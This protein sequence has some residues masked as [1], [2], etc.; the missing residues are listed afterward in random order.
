MLTSTPA[1]ATSFAALIMK[2][3]VNGEIYKAAW[4]GNG[5]SDA[6]L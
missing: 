6:R 2:I 4:R 3:S 1:L 5:L